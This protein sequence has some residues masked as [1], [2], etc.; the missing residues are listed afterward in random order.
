MSRF[1]NVSPV[2]STHNVEGIQTVSRTIK[3]AAAAAAAVAA[4]GAT[5]LYAA[6]A[7]ASDAGARSAATPLATATAPA[8]AATAAATA[9]LGTVLTGKLAAKVKAAA[10]KA[11]P[12]CTV[13]RV[14]TAPNHGYAAHVVD[15][16]GKRLVILFNHSLKVQSIKPD[17]VVTA[18]KPAPKPTPTSSPTATIVTV[19]AATPTA[20]K[21]TRMTPPLSKK[22]MAKITAAVRAKLPGSK[23][24][25]MAANK[26]GY[27]AHVI[28]PKGK[29]LLV[30]LNA[31][32][33]IT[34]IRPE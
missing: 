32:F 14:E 10:L 30:K 23:I 25:S 26:G 20:T 3:Q 19:R 17:T 1:G 7:N 9:K 28:T 33:V 22:A 8:P 34:S 13:T 2:R 27:V 5:G 18:P 12:G 21:T 4:L 15:R 29:H 6:N 24:T 31:K 16:K 11:V